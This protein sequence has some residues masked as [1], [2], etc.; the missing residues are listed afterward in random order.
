MSRALI[1][2][3]AASAVSL[4]SSTCIRFLVEMVR[5][6]ISQ[7]LVRKQIA[8]AV[9]SF[10]GL[11]DPGGGNGQR[12]GVGGEH[13]PMACAGQVGR[14][15]GEARRGLGGERRVETFELEIEAGACR[16]RDMGEL[17]EPLPA[18]PGGQR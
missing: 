7:N 5:P 17:V 8:S 6:N 13:A 3:S 9:P 1:S 11:A 18:R 12:G 10:K 4:I 16:H 2:S 15:R 14:A